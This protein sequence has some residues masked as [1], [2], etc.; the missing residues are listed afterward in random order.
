[1]LYT[2]PAGFYD[3]PFTW[4]F[5]CSALV[6]GQN[7]PRL[8]V[9]IY[10]GYGDFIMRRIVGLNNV[11]SNVS[12]QFQI[13]DQLGRYLQNV[14]Q[15]IGSGGPGQTAHCGADFGLT[16]E[17]IYPENSQIYFDLYD[18]DP[19]FDYGGISNF[20]AQVGFQGVRR[21][22]G[23]SPWP[24]G[25]RFKPKTY[26]Y[27]VGN[28]LPTST[29]T[30]GPAEHVITPITDFDFELYEL[31]IAYSV[32]GMAVLNTRS[33]CLLQLFDQNGVGV[34]YQPITDQYLNAL[35]P[36]KT[37]AFVPPLLYRKDSQIRLDMISLTAGTEVDM[38]IQYVGRQRIPVQ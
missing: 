25:Y 21:V 11:L 19:A 24:A 8:S 13:R 6:A 14:P 22:E 5:D 17:L 28:T 15:S 30:L 7:Y 12:G 38:A 26:T 1:M 31:Q 23:N 27:I 2:P 34:Q 29:A 35:S 33:L 20:G 16:R 10:A 9:P 37:G 32:N 4:V 3:V 18:V 36:W